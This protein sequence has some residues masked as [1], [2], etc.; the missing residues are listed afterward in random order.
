VGSWPRPLFHWNEV[1]GLPAQ[2]DSFI[3]T[4][5]FPK[6]TTHPVQAGVDIKTR[7]GKEISRLKVAE[8]S[9]TL[10]LMDLAGKTHRL[11][12]RDLHESHDEHRSSI[13]LVIPCYG[14][15]E[16][17]GGRQ[18]RLSRLVGGSNW[19]DLSYDPVHSTLYVVARN[20][21]MGYR[22]TSQSTWLPAV[23]RQYIGGHPP[24]SAAG[25]LHRSP[26]TQIRAR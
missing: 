17:V 24:R 13:R 26:S 2:G 21:G 11:D 9:Y 16:A 20:S 19:Q 4:T 1:W 22:S 7:T 12:T 15:V 8:D 14:R 5:H 6:L 23:H 10:N 3:P 25:Q 18:R